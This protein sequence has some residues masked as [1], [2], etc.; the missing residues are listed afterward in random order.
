MLTGA[1]KGEAT[2]RRIV[3]WIELEFET[4]GTEHRW[5]PTFSKPR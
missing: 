4:G 1:G 3:P 2:V 5:Q